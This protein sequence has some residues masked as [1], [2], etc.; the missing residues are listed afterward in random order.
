[1]TTDSRIHIHSMMRI[2][3]YAGVPFAEFRAGFENAAPPFDPESV[4]RIVAAQGEHIVPT[5]HRR[6]DRGRPG[7]GPQGGR[8][9]AGHWGRLGRG[10]RA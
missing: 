3:V 4:R 6:G 10:V 9:V 7:S 8:P 5:R 2:D 1:M